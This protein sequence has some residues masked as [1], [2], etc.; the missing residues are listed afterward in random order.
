LKNMA[1]INSQG[2]ALPALMVFTTIL[3][4]GLTRAEINWQKRMQREREEELLFRGKQYMRA[5]M[6]FQRKTGFY[7]TSVEALLNTNNLRFLRKRWKDPITNSE[8]WR[9]IRLSPDAPLIR[10]MG[11]GTGGTKGASLAGAGGQQTSTSPGTQGGLGMPGFNQAGSSLGQSSS[12]SQRGRSETGS[13][14]GSGMIMYPLIGVASKSEKESIRTFNGQTK[15][16][17]WEFM[18]LPGMNI[19][20]S[21]GP[22]SLGFAAGGGP[23][24]PNSQPGLGPGMPAGNQP[25]KATGLGTGMRPGMGSMGPGMQN[26]GFE[27]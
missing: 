1:R 14:G 18:Y 3:L 13:L 19:T 17:R 4:V 12:F 8:D 5:V 24:T 26:P 7:P 11:G 20:W 10:S 23:V 6:L 22:G 25:G 21:V 15:Y 27:K 9:W 2:Y 16:N